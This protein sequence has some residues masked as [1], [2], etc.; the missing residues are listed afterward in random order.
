MPEIP[1]QEVYI[2]ITKKKEM[3]KPLG[4]DLFQKDLA[5]IL[6]KDLIVVH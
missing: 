5:K 6:S 3:L 2:P 1:R 4:M